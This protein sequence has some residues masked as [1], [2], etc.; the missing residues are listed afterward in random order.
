LQRVAVAPERRE[1]LR[2]L[3][4]AL[5]GEEEILAPQRALDERN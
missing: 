1:E 5:G 4:G 2:L 3:A